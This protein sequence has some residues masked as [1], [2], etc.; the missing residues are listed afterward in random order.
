M[1]R[2][3]WGGWCGTQAGDASDETGLPGIHGTGWK[4]GSG[5][6]SRCGLTPWQGPTP[7]S[8]P[9]SH[10][11]LGHIF[12][13][14][15]EGSL[16]WLDYSSSP[17]QPTHQLLPPTRGPTGSFP[18]SP[19]LLQPG[20]PT[21]P[22]TL[23]LA[24]VPLG[25]GRQEAP[26]VG[27]YPSLPS[28]APGLCWEEGKATSNPPPPPPAPPSPLCPPSAS[29]LSPARPL[30]ASAIP[31]PLA[32]TSSSCVCLAKGPT[33]CSALSWTAWLGDGEGGGQGKGS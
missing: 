33:V 16:P 1:R 21:F 2:I 26:T 29:R 19:E 31:A 5:P 18:P 9:I 25:K 3:P 7:V 22:A 10:L 27:L 6:R 11:V 30:N 20:T 8:P 23:A 15:S 17:E 24:S 4:D 12:G 28:P 32:L 14:Y 13:I